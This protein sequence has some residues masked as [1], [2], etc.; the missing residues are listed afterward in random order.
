MQDTTQPYDGL[1]G[2]YDFVMRHVEYGQWAEY[3]DALLERYECTPA[4]IIDIACGTGSLSLALHALNRPV[5]QGVDRSEPMLRLAR[6]RAL[7]NG[8]D[9]QF[10]ARDM[11]DL[12]GLGPYEAAMCIYDSINYMLQPVDLEAVLQAVHDILTPG[13]WFVFDVCTETN[14]LRYFNDVRDR[15]SGPGFR[16]YR[17]SRYIQSERFQINDFVIRFDDGAI[18]VQEHHVQRIYRLADIQRA[19]ERT[20]FKLLG[21]FDEF[22]FSPGTEAS[23]RVH[24]ALQRPLSSLER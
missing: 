20:G 17:H 15:E 13:G 21:T 1:A 12:H 8:C 10:A 5:V 22:T 16:Y 4:S 6:E 19:V 2:I 3:I 18:E 24:F 23:E 9:I 11:R 14:S 7:R